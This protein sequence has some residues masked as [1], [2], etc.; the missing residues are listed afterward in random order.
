VPAV[1]T[2]RNII[3]QIKHDGTPNKESQIAYDRLLRD[4]MADNTVGLCVLACTELPLLLTCTAN[5]KNEEDNTTRPSS[6]IHF[7]DPTIAVANALLTATQTYPREK[8]IS[9]QH[10]DGQRVQHD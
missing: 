10:S 5:N 1:E 7:I 2:L 9:I 8:L 3:W 6:Q 4:E